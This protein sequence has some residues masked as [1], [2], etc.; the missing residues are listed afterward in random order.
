MD[1][2]HLKSPLWVKACWGSA[3]AFV[4][5]IS[6]S[7]IGVNGV[8]MLFNLSGVPGMLIVVASAFAFIKMAQRVEVNGQ[9]VEL[10]QDAL[11]ALESGQP[12]S[13]TSAAQGAAS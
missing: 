2:E 7:Y 12:A 8:K 3:I 11:A 9:T 6:A 4:A 13:Q 5:W 1:A 10:K